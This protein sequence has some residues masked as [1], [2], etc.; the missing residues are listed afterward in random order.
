MDASTAG[1]AQATG[2]SGK[3]QTISRQLAEFVA[4]FSYDAIP[5]A[6]RSRAK[7]L[8]LDAVGIAL[9][10]TQYD[11]SH[12]TLSGIRSLAGSGDCSVIGMKERLPLRDAVLMNGGLVHGLDYDDTH[13]RAIVHPTASAF[14]CALSVAEQLGRSGRDLLTAYILGVEIVT[15]ICDAAK[16]HFHDFGFHPTGIGAHFSFAPPT[17]RLH[18]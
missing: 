15:R 2:A 8:I 18:R 14:V 12:R 4:S 13:I 16:G 10:S 1:L 11:F 3:S 9:A 6:I 17:G 5:E 7:S